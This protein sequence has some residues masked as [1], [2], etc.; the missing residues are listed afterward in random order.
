MTL[1]LTCLTHE[2]IVQLSDRR[3][4][5]I[6]TR[7]PED[8]DTNKVVGYWNIAAFSYTGLSTINGTKTDRWIFDRLV[9]LVD[10]GQFTP[11]DLGR[12]LAARAT[13]EFKKSW[14]SL[15][16]N[17]YRSHAFVY[18]AWVT[19]PTK[20]I[21]PMISTVSNF[22][23]RQGNRLSEPSL[24]FSHSFRVLDPFVPCYLE[25]TGQDVEK[26][27]ITEAETQIRACVKKKTGPEPMARILRTLM[28]EVSA[29]NKAVGKN[30]LEMSLPIKAYSATDV[31]YSSLQHNRKTATFHYVPEDQ[32]RGVI[33]SP[34]IVS[35][36]LVLG[37][38]V[39]YMPPT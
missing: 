6:A 17:N 16:P 20:E 24:F 23:D 13:D 15:L 19:L 31:S 28:R 34:L 36:I 14:I 9:P 26:H 29:R 21:R 25:A 27:L 1:I 5:N 33:Y 3:L 35:A 30:L 10:P 39:T 8:D 22:H 38:S 11:F 2:F 32:D 12:E 18:G 37:M 7:K 4:V